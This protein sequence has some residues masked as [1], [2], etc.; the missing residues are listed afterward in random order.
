MKAKEIY[1]T[2]FK[3]QTAR[4][5]L[6]GKDLFIGRNGSG[7]TTRIQALSLAMLGHVPENGKKAQETFKLATGEDMTAG[8]KLDSGFDFAR[9]L[10]R[11]V[12][13]DK[14]TG[15]TSVT[16]SESV[17]VLPG[18][19][20]KN[21]TQK[22]ARISAEVGDFAVMLDIDEF[23]KLSDAKRRDFFYSL[24]PIS[25]DSWSKEQIKVHLSGTMLTDGKSED[26]KEVVLSVNT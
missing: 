2:N 1:F 20:E 26:Y 22:K 9:T 21:D 4:Q 13:T 11:N 24:S 25:T 8:M 16:I 3:G 10:T 14:K 15:A 19:G 18:K 6:T 17:N 12:K 5:P 23:L 7:K